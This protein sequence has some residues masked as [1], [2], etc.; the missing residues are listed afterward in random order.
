MN[1]SYLCISAFATAVAGYVLLKSFDSKWHIF[2]AGAFDQTNIGIGGD[3]VL[4][5]MER[6]ES[7]AR[8]SWELGTVAE[9]SLEF[10]DPGV[11]VF[12]S[13]PFPDGKIPTLNV[14]NIRGLRFAKRH[15]W[16]D[17]REL[18][19]GSGAAGDP[20]SLG[21]ASILIGQSELEYQEA[22]Q[23]QLDFLLH[24]VPRWAS[25]AISHRL[26]YAELWADFVYM[27]PPFLAYMAV[28]KNDTGL[29]KEGIQQIR[30][31][32]N[33]LLAKTIRLDCPPLWMHIVG[34][35]N[36]DL[37]F[38]CTSNG[39]AAAGV[40]RVIA[41]IQK[42]G[43]VGQAFEADLADLVQYV[44][45]ILDGVH[46]VD[47]GND[48]LLRNYLDDE[49]WFREGAGTAALAAT[50]YRM[51]VLERTVFGRKYIKWADQKY[52]SI[53]K[54]IDRRTGVLAPVVYPLNHSDREPLLSGSSE[55]QS[56]VTLMIAAQKDCRRL[57]IC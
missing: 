14:S 18:Q 39:W 52:A 6:A 15:I 29:L 13:S 1:Y 48:E 28:A 19:E 36:P 30:L 26:K 5:V 9:A 31:Y 10:F 56:F 41:T 57:R 45:E 11:S 34:P 17:R 23:R 38:W 42:S 50:A 32:R 49:S 12:G 47:T 53:A 4:K 7:L 55:G 25:G 16:T 35:K 54:H 51:A 3:L 40:A 37:G 8:G 27:V 2:E 46:C 44:K 33:V 20:P 24:S 22:A 21:I 43:I